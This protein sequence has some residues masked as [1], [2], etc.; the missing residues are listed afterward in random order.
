MVNFQH[1]L[2]LWKDVWKIKREF[3]R[4]IV[5]HL[6]GNVSH[7]TGQNRKRNKPSAQLGAPTKEV[8]DIMN[9][10]KPRHPRSLT[11]KHATQGSK[12]K[13][14]ESEGDGLGQVPDPSRSS[15]PNVEKEEKKQ[16]VIGGRRAALGFLVSIKK[17]MGEIGICM[18]CAN[19]AHDGDCKNYEEAAGNEKAMKKIRELLSNDHVSSDEEM[20]DTEEPCSSTSKERK[21]GGQEGKETIEM[22]SYTL[23][24]VEMADTAEGG[25]LQRGGVDLTYNP[26]GDN[27][28]FK[29]TL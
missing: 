8:L 13:A 25:E 6:A 15:Q 11:A 18:R 1:E 21:K 2:P 7:T 16:R 9:K 24:L 14:T 12:R 20:G 28:T 22:Y 26:C 10:T 29:T 27:R 4:S 3:E 23:N 17:C 5:R 19:L